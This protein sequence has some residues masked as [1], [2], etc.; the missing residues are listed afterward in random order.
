MKFYHIATLL[1]FSAFSVGHLSAQVSGNA[2]WNENNRFKNNAT[3]QTQ[4]P[5]AA[6]DYDGRAD[7]ISGKRATLVQGNNT[8]RPNPG[9]EYTMAYVK[10]EQDIISNANELVINVSVLNNASPTSY[11]AIFH[12]NQAGKKVSELD[13]LLQMRVNK[14]MKM[15]ASLGIKEKDYY[16][17][18]IALVPIFQRE[19]KLFSNTYTEIPKGFEMQKNLH[20]RYKNPEQLDKL[21]TMAAQCEIYDLIKVEYHCDTIQQANVRIRQK[22][23]ELL[24]QKLSHLKKTGIV[25][26]TNFR[27]VNEFQKQY[28]PVDQYLSYQPLAISA[29]EDET[30]PAGT[31]K[32]ATRPNRQTLF[33]NAISTNGFDA[34]LNPSPLQPSI[35]MVY[36]MEVRYTLVQPVRTVTQTQHQTKALIITPQGTIKEEYITK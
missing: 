24:K 13:S 4:E 30:S 23:D 1:G 20:V 8:Y 34:I 31:E 28:F 21:F 26:D 14:L 15:S 32:I 36:S 19:K 12:L 2:T 3:Y 16:L 11:T 33:H 25:L 6:M 9:T 29:I 5:S 35:Q 7:K 17:D 18:M 27:T 22:A 10:R